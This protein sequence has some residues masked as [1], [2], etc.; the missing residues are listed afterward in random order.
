MAPRSSWTA[1]RKSPTGISSVLSISLTR[2]RSETLRAVVTV[3]KAQSAIR[4]TTGTI[5]SATIFDRTERGIGP[6]RRLRR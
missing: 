4:D 5:S 2:S 1:A 3:A 6:N